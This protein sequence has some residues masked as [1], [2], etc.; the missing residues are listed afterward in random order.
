MAV[1]TWDFYLLRNMS[2]FMLMDLII[3]FDYLHFT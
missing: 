2:W 3:L 1:L